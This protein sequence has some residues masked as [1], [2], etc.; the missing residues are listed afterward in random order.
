[1]NRAGHIPTEPLPFADRAIQIRDIDGSVV[2]CDA[3]EVLASLIGVREQLTAAQVV[4]CRRF[5]D[6]EHL[7][8]S[9]LMT[10]HALAGHV[11]VRTA[12]TTNTRILAH[13]CYASGFRVLPRDSKVLQGLVSGS[14]MALGP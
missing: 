4:T 3:S 12:R 11:T 2:R 14:S 6:R 7:L 1:M 5:F 13:N 9:D 10:S 8:R